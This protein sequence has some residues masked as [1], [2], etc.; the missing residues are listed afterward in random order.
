MVKRIGIEEEWKDFIRKRAIEELERAIKDIEAKKFEGY[1]LI[2]RNEEEPYDC[3]MSPSVRA[4][5]RAELYVKSMREAVESE[6]ETQKS[7]A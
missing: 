4:M 1:I 2:S 3:I 7:Y 5:R 6:F